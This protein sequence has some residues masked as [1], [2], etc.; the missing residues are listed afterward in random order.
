MELQVLTF[1]HLSC[2]GYVRTPFHLEIPEFM[3]PSPA[4]LPFMQL[5]SVHSLRKEDT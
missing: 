4:Q 2:F 5:E 1:D 3:P